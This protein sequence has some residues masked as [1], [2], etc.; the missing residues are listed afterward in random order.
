MSNLSK[1]TIARIASDAVKSYPLTASHTHTDGPRAGYTKG[2]LHEAERAQ[3]LAEAIFLIYSNGL[4]RQATTDAVN[5][6]LLNYY[7]NQTA[8]DNALAKYKEV[9]K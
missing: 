2:A 9:T 3:V 1:E 4:N 8:V 5:K 7:G 6:A